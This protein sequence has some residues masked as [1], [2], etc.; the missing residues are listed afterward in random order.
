MVVSIHQPNFCPWYPFF[1]KM[2]RSD[3]FVILGHCQYEK[4]GFQ[5]RFECD[6]WNTM[7]VN[8]GLEPIVDK[9][10][11]NHIADWNK[12][13]A[14][15]PHLKQFDDC[16]SDSLYKTNVNIIRKTAK[17]L[18]LNTT[19][20]YDYRTNLT[21]TERLVSLCKLYGADTYL[22]GSSGKKY[23]DARQFGR[24]KVIYQEDKT[25]I[26]FPDFIGVGAEKLY[27]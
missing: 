27:I 15:Y 1:E 19:I 16:I 18:K 3:V 17:L 4:N 14:K 26:S 23:L 5:N 6:G 11:V 10:Y 12:I 7:S 13:T 21:G 2:Q 24:I 25:P 9:K 8:K 20:A 22:S